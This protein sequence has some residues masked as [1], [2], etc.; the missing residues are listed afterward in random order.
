MAKVLCVLYPDPVMGYA[1]QHARDD[2]PAIE[3]Y[4][5]G[6]E[7]PTPSAIDFRPGELLG[8]VG[9]TGL[10]KVPSINALGLR[11]CNY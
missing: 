11:C 3:V 4:P 9:R 1:P 10:T 7:T 2:A 5:N 8:C 6:Q